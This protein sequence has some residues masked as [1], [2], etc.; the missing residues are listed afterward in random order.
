MMAGP[1]ILGS[2]PLACF[3]ISTM[4]KLSRRFC[5]SGR[6]LR[7]SVTLRSVFRVLFS[8][9]LSSRV[10]LVDTMRPVYNRKQPHRSIPVRRIPIIVWV[11]ATAGQALS[12]A[13]AIFRLLALSRFSLFQ[14]YWQRPPRYLCP[15]L[16]VFQALLGVVSAIMASL[17]NLSP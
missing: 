17:N 9:I 3:I 15:R 12:P 1:H 8:A 10:K 16:Q 7:K 5:S 6:L 13:A 14:Q 11:E 4:L 2:A